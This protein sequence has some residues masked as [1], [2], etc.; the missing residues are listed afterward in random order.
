MLISTQIQQIKEMVAGKALLRIGDIWYGND[1]YSTVTGLYHPSQKNIQTL[2]P[3]R[4]ESA[5]SFSNS[6]PGINVFQIQI[7]VHKSQ[8]KAKIARLSASI[9][10]S[11]ILPVMNREIAALVQPVEKFNNVY[12]AYGYNLPPS[13]PAADKIAAYCSVPV[14]MK[15]D[16]VNITTIPGHP[17]DFKLTVMMKKVL[18]ANFYGDKTMYVK[19]IQD[20]VSQEIF[21]R[22]I[23]NKGGDNEQ[24]DALG[25]LFNIDVDGIRNA[26]D[27]M[28]PKKSKDTAKIVEAVLVKVL[29]YDLFEVT[30]DG[31]TKIVKLFGVETYFNGNTF[32]L[33]RK[34]AASS[35]LSTPVELFI[36]KLNGV[37]LL[38][39][40]IK[41][42]SMDL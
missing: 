40:V 2:I 33:L 13:A 22:D 6:S 36:Q 5:I 37:N 17:D 24:I 7:V 8:F 38:H 12:M 9:Q 15:I 20:A 14:M 26:I 42:S 31:K 25:S 39:P 32:S 1:E 29:D 11:P 4:A 28:N 10:V 41:K 35:Y 16:S 19:S 23:Q 21:I 34:K 30:I 18:T 27:N 3:I